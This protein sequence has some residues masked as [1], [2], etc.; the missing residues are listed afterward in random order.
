MAYTEKTEKSWFSRLGG[1][2]TGMAA[3]LAL[4]VAGSWLLYYNEGRS[5]ATGDAIAEAETAAVELADVTT[6]DPAFEGKMVHAVGFADTRDVLTD[7]LFGVRTTAVSLKRDVEFYQWVEESRSETRKKLGGGTETITTYSYR[8]QWTN[9]PVDSARFR[10]PGYTGKNSVPVTIPDETFYAKNVAFGAYQLPSFVIQSLTDSVPVAV[11]L[12]SE[13]TAKWNRQIGSTDAGAAGTE[14]RVHVQDSVVYLGTSPHLPQ[15]GDVRV[16]FTEVR[17]SGI[18]LLA[19]VIDNTFEPF[20]ASNG[21]TFSRVSMGTLSAEN[22]FGDAASGNTILTW[23][24]RGA[25]AL[26]VII[27]LALFTAP[28]SVLAD[29]IP[30][31]G[32]IVGAGTFA[33]AFLLGLAWSFVMIAAAWLRFRPL[34]GGSLLAAAAV[35]V[36]LLRVRGRKAAQS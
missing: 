28:L 24:L 31:L 33:I 36:V 13:D 3:G 32:T 10:D 22:M 27:A 2:F 25:G 20:R 23:I 26:L 29:V 9:K 8:Q 17:P 34:I 35:L 4:F 11:S 7:P 16:T 21:N 5:V 1:A 14:S 15:I 19:K 6:I 30:L 18:S 12:T